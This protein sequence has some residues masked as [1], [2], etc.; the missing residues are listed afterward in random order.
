MDPMTLS[1]IMGGAQML[2]GAQKEKSSKQLAAATQRYSPW[3]NL[4]AGPVKYA[5]PVSTGMQA[6][7]TGLADQQGIE[8]KAA[9][10]KLLEAQTGFYNRGYGGMENAGQGP[11]AA[12]NQEMNPF[13]R[14]RADYWNQQAN[15]PLGSNS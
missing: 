10:K 12:I 6:Y 13:P 7:G 14:M 1:M 3:T 15:S 5:D 9:Q 11:I 2:N 4:A 8:N